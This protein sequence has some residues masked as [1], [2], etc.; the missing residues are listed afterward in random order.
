MVAV[1][2]DGN[3]VIRSVWDMTDIMQ[4]TASTPDVEKFVA[5]IN[6]ANQN[7]RTRIAARQ[8]RKK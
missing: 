1:R 6:V 7:E 2:R 3:R 8:G 4:L 5:Q